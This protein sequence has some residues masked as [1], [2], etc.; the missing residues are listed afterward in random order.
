MSN[1]YPV[2]ILSRGNLPVECCDH[3]ESLR[4]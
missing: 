1:Y 4:Y 3:T 2:D